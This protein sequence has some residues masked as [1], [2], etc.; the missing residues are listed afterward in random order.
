MNDIRRILNVLVFK[1]FAAQI[2]F[3]DAEAPY[4]AKK[5]ITTQLT[6]ILTPADHFKFTARNCF[7]IYHSFYSIISIINT[8]VHCKPL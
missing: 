8:F 6:Q 5:F 7:P 4:C 3:L 2:I 1:S